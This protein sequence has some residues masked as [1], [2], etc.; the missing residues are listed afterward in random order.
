MPAATWAS[1]STTMPSPAPPRRPWQLTMEP[2]ACRGWGAALGGTG[3]GPWLCVRSCGAPLPGAVGGMLGQDGDSP[4]WL[5]VPVPQAAPLPDQP[6]ACHHQRCTLPR[7]GGQGHLPPRPRGTLPWH[8]EQHLPRG[9]LCPGTPGHAGAAVPLSPGSASLPAC[10]V[11][12][13]CT[14]RVPPGSDH[15]SPQDDTRT[16]QDSLPEKTVVKLGALPR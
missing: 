3:L 10:A 9:S 8:G 15:S 5:T 11:L 14:G 12:G 13:R 6:E 16:S 7:A 1:S 4:G 2:G